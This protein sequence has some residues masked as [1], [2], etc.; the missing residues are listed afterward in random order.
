MGK[1]VGGFV[2]E[3][4]ESVD[5]AVDGVQH[6]LKKQERKWEK[7]ERKVREVEEVVGGMNAK[8]N[9][10]SERGHRGSL[11]LNRAY[12]YSLLAYVLPHLLLDFD[13]PHHSLYSPTSTIALRHHHHHYQ[14]HCLHRPRWKLSLRK[15]IRPL[16]M[17]GVR[18]N[19]S[20]RSLRAPF[21][22][23]RALLCGW[24]IF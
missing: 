12:A 5:E 18:R 13:A 8:L 14:H 24:G 22:L 23:L 11:S 10:S 7:W 1:R 6:S 16:R 9:K 15:T 17:G 21:G 20:T 2:D 3:V 19:I 4:Y